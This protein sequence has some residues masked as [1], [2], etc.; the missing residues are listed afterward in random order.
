MEAAIKIKLK[1]VDPNIPSLT[2]EQL[3]SRVRSKKHLYD[4]AAANGYVLPGRKS[5][6][7]S[8]DWLLDLQAKIMWCP[9]AVDVKQAVICAR[10]PPN[11]DI[12]REIR[13]AVTQ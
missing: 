11:E 12:V 2:R 8:K 7:V 5:N 3:K 6:M 9:K 10:P 4:A 1:M 13:E